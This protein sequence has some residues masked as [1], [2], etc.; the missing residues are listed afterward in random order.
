MTPTLIVIV[1]VL[2]G[3]GIVAWATRRKPTLPASRSD[4]LPA[5]QD[6]AWNDPVRPEPPKAADA[7]H[8]DI[9]S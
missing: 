3:V 1:L 9:R 8:T 4:I 6:T 2:I 7:P 5:D